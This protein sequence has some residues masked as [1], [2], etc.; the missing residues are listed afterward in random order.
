MTK[1][2]P[3]TQGKFALVDDED[4][5]CLSSFKWHYHSGYAKRGKFIS[6]IDGKQKIKIFYMHREIIK[7][8]DDM[9]TD[10]IDGDGLNNQRHNLRIASRAQNAMNSKTI[11]KSFSNVKGVSWHKGAGKWQSK[12]V[13]N[14]QTK[15]L[16]HFADIDSATQAYNAAA[17][18]HFGEFARL[19]KI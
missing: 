6:R 4:F 19:N 17:I 16:G 1:K 13:V 8:P 18:E 3:L 15:Y 10:H 14:G 12:I 5:E 11:K 7:T 2:I 9:I